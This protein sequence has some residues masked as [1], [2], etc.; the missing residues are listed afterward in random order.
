MHEVAD[1]VKPQNIDARAGP[2][3]LATGNFS[4]GLCV[5]DLRAHNDYSEAEAIDDAHTGCVLDLD[6]RQSLLLSSSRLEV[7][8]WDVNR[9]QV[10]LVATPFPPLLP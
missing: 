1:T 9:L 6:V 8:L 5:Y 2:N 10:R 4:G 7:K 3:R